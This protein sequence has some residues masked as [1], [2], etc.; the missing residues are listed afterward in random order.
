MLCF[1]ICMSSSLICWNFIPLFY[2][3]HGSIVWIFWNES[4]KLILLVF[5]KMYFTLF[6]TKFCLIHS[7][8]QTKSFHAQLAVCRHHF[9]FFHSTLS[10]PPRVHCHNLCFISNWTSRPSDPTWHVALTFVCL[11]VWF[12][13]IKP[14]TSNL[15]WSC[16]SVAQ[17]ALKQFASKLWINRLCVSTH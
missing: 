17:A 4:F 1:T 13:R 16:G 12:A 15:K 10:R 8:W 9:S 5:N 2:L 14:S 11:F 6:T 3:Y 7:I